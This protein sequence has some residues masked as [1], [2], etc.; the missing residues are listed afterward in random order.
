MDTLWFVYYENTN[1]LCLLIGRVKCESN[2]LH[3]RNLIRFE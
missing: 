1:N 2:C 3:K